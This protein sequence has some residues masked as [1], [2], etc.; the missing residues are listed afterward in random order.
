MDSR[1][2]SFQTSGLTFDKNKR[3]NFLLIFLIALNFLTFF[4]TFFINVASAIPTLGI[5][6][7][8]LQSINYFKI[9]LNK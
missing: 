5:V 7:L 9:N 6:S 4:V 8:T 1:S 3:N 2:S